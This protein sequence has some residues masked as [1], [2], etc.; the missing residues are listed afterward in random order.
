MQLSQYIDHTLLK[1]DATA[2]QIEKLCQEALQYKFFSVCV[3]S[4]YVPLCKKLTIGS[5][6]KVCSVVGFPLGSMDTSSKSFET[7]QAIKNGADEIDMVIHIG[8][9]KDRK[10]DLLVQDI[11]A[12][13]GSASG[14]VVKVII[15]TSLLSDEEKVL[16][17]EA[18][19]RAGAHYVKTS[20]GFNGGGAT[21]EDVRLMK[22]VVGN[23]ALVKASGGI[24]DQAQAL[25]MIEAGA[26]RLGTSS[27]ILIIHGKT[28]QGGY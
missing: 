26:S 22:S 18:S 24:K 10:F 28:A 15:E 6:V 4:V 21:L 7:Q 19:V 14:K 5:D 9:L 12:V 1:P 8:A 11:A 27:G 13:V 3:N 16:A 17:C 25:A 23:H 2:E 20:T